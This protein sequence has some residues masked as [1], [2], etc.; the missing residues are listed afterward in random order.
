MTLESRIHHAAGANIKGTPAMPASAVQHDLNVLRRRADVLMLQEFRW[1]WY[2]GVAMRVLANGKTWGS[3]PSFNAGKNASTRGAQG[4]T[5]NRLKWKRIKSRMWLLHKGVAAVSEDRYLRAVLLQDRKTKQ[6]CWFVSSHFVVGGD[7][8]HDSHLR[9]SMMAG[10]IDV[11]RN[12]LRTLERSGFPVIAEV[13]ANIHKGSA[14]YGEW[15]RM[16]ADAGAKVYGTHGVEYLFTVNGE[17]T[18]V[19]A[20]R[21]WV[22]PTSQ[23]RTDH[24]TRGLTYRLVG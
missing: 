12:V 21:A 15:I 13:D 22:I 2:W 24:E 1:P 9:K 4:I 11:V 3:S 17:E 5:W 18:K 14:V 7:E 20:I 16:L 19:D 6:F 23:L 10:D 8:D